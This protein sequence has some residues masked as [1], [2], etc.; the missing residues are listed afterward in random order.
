MKNETVTYAMP[1]VGCLIGAAF[2]RLTAQ[3]EAALKAAGLKISP[4]E[5]MILRALYSHDG[6]QQCEIGVMVGKDKA[7][8]SRS[9]TALAGKGLVKSEQVSHKCCRVWLTAGGRDIEQRIMAVAD[10]RHK[11]LTD[12]VSGNDLEAFLRVLRAIMNDKQTE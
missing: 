4:A 10:A 1:Y 12:M 2:Q 8:I 3:L 9:V 5:Y 11:A 6:L 7:A